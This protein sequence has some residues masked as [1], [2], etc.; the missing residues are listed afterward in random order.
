MKP[1]LFDVPPLYGTIL[2]G[3][4]V[5]WAIPELLGAFLL[6]SAA[7]ATKHD[8]GSY[9][10]VVGGIGIGIIGALWSAT[11][12]PVLALTSQRS[13]LFWLGILLMLAGL[14]FRWY[15][16]LTLG[17][18]FTHDVAT[19]V[20]Q[21]LVERGPYRRLRHPAYSGVLL[22]LLGLGLVLANWGSLCLLLLGGGLG[23]GYR[24]R[25][26]EQ[27][28]Q[29]AFGQRYTAYRQRTQRLIPWLW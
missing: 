19:Y 28:L 2:M 5:V 14:V 26:E 16:I 22:T 29:A 17:R 6:R 8:Q 18:S 13:T 23:L 27:A 20:D 25:I 3:V 11:H 7:T 4:I 1:L 12:F 24:M 15:A 21:P 10:A 9:F